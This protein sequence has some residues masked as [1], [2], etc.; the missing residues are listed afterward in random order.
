[1]RRCLFKEAE[2]KY[3][4]PKS[5]PKCV[6]TLASIQASNSPRKPLSGTIKDEQDQVLEKVAQ[7]MLKLASP[8]P[9]QVDQRL[10][11]NGGEAL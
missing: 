2:F 9:E 5:A 4:D 10:E 1:V 7:A 6:F 11:L 3:T 8:T